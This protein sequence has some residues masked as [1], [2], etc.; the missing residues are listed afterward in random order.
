MEL[1]IFTFGDL[2]AD[3]VT[4]QPANTHG[5]FLRLL[6]LAETADQAG[7]DV[8]ALGEH[9]RH[10]FVLSAPEVVLGAMA[11][12]TSRIRLSTSVTVLSTQDPVRVFQQFATLDQVSNGRAE[13]MAGRGAFVES[14]PLFGYDLD[15]YEE[16]FDEKIQLLMQL[17]ESEIVT[18]QGRLRHSL[19]NVGVYPRPYQNRLPVWIGVGGTPQSAVR[20]GVL[21]AP[22]FM[23]FQ[24]GKRLVDLYR[25]AGAQAGHEPANLRTAS[26]G[27]VFVG[28]TSQEARDAYF[29]Y[30]ADY[31][32]QAPQFAGGMP[33]AAFEQWVAQDRLMV[34]SPQQI[35]D[36]ILHHHELLGTDRYLAQIEVGGMP[37]GMVNGSLEL[38]ATEVA[39]VLRRETAAVKESA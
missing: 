9:H 36:G 37:Q 21:G 12:L 15:D 5:R 7:L 18:W 35:I 24:G 13:V 22:M 16:L 14:F 10:D 34:G 30:Y 6:E 19:D 8:L 32:S 11:S 2:R 27:H 31:L 28:R 20:A 33:R 29:P 23:P 39:P 38:Y 1:G 26:G 4:G 25:A 17:R 3:P